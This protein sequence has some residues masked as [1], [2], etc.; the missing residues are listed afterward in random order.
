MFINW[1]VKAR[2][3]SQLPLAESGQ[4]GKPSMQFKAVLLHAKLVLETGENVDECAHDK[5]EKGNPNNHHWDGEQHF[6]ICFGFQVSIANSWQGCDDVVARWVQ[7]GDGLKLSDVVLSVWN[8]RRESILWIVD[9]IRVK[10]EHAPQKVGDYNSLH[11]QVQDSVNIFEEHFRD[12]FS[13]SRAGHV[14]EHF[15]EFV[16]SL[17]IK[18]SHYSSESEQSDQFEHHSLVT[19]SPSVEQIKRK[20]SQEIENKH[21]S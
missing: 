12:D 17:H 8:P 2:R 20:G 11:D 10:V 7:T 5:G 21:S 6:G 1:L 13:S 18:Q 19:S 15:K 16:D 9:S 3:N 14:G 4:Q